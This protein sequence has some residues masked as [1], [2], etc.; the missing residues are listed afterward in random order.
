M[1]SNVLNNDMQNNMFSGTKM[2]ILYQYKNA[3]N[4][5]QYIIQN[6]A[7]HVQNDVHCFRTET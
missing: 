1:Q 4:Y 7:H 3:K 5:M 2:K 6:T